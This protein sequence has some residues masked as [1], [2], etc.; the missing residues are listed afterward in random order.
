MKK[1]AGIG[2]L[3]LLQPATYKFEWLERSSTRHGSGE[4]LGRRVKREQRIMTFPA[5]LKTGDNTGRQF[6]KPEVLCK[7][8]YMEEYGTESGKAGDL[9][10]GDL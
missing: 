5:L 3:L 7:P 6:R 10:R 2:V 1:S 4:Q 9:V 8:E